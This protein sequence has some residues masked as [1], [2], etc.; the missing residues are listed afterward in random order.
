MQTHERG[1]VHRLATLSDCQ[2]RGG[3]AELAAATAGTML[4]T[5]EGMESQRL[6]DRLV[7][8]RRSL[9]GLQ[10]RATADGVGRID[11]TLR[12]PV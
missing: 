8:V 10:S 9:V 5:M 4:D 12:I 6:R 11:D 7:K 1:R 3:E 2:L